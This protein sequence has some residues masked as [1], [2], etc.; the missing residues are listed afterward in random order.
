MIL[1]VNSACWPKLASDSVQQ[2]NEA[3]EVKKGED[4]LFFSEI[5]T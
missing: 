3:A 1:D 5:L 2:A 4:P